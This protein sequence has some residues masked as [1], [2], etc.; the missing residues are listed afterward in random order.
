VNGAA[1]ADRSPAL[2]TG[3]NRITDC[4]IHRGG[5]VF[6]ASV[7]IHAMHTYCNTFAHNEID[8]LFYS[9]ISVGWQWDYKANLTRDNTVAFNHIHH[10]GQGML[11]DMGG[12]YTL[13]VQPGTVIRNNHIHDVYKL[14]YGA[15]CIYPDE[16]S[17]HI[18]IENNVCHT[19]NGEIFHQHYGRDNIVRNNIFAF[20]EVALVAYSNWVKPYNGYRMYKNIMLT[21][22]EAFF[23]A[24]YNVKL[25]ENGHE[26]NMNLLWNYEGDEIRFAGKKSTCEGANEGIDLERWQEI[27]NDRHSVVIDP[28]CKDPENLDFALA[29]DSPA[30]EAIGF[31]PIDMS[32][33]GPR[34]AVD[35]HHWAPP[36]DKQRIGN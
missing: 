34:P 25:D 7:G 12:V 8:N 33:I 21:K 15:W 13:G 22:G 2:E 17:S 29:E 32:R 20:A 26:T 27:G 30:L 14:N 6:C 36:H 31:T 24:G 16:G 28:K 10:L 4:H 35:R 9:G 1:F 23:L 19:T 18:L 5:R 3:H 11:S